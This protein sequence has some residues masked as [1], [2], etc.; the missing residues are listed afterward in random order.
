MQSPS[1]ANARSWPG[2][3]NVL[4]VTIPPD[5]YD[6]VK[7]IA[8]IKKVSASWVIRDAVEIYVQTDKE[9]DGVRPM[10]VH[11]ISDHLTTIN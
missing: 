10:I 7:R 1:S 9:P 8:K 11:P 4:T 6:A 3:G 2:S 5:D